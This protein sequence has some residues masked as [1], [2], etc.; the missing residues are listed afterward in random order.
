MMAENHVIPPLV[1]CQVEGC[2]AGIMPD[3]SQC[4]ECWGTGLV[5][6]QE[7]TEESANVDHNER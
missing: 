6:E 7:E 4:D 2:H 3:G 5:S 1:S